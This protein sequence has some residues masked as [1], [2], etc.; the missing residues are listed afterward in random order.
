MKAW[1]GKSVM[2]VAIGHTI[3]GLIVFGP[4]LRTF[5]DGGIVNT[6]TAGQ[7]PGREAAFWFLFTGFAILVIGGLVD[8][9]EKHDLAI[10]L[11]VGVSTAIL[12][13][14]GIIV[15]PMSGFWLMIIPLVGLARSARQQ[16]G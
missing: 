6:I 10:P 15:M 14:I 16:R 13:I 3:V 11:F 8:Y 7:N 12:T 9:L 4:A 2:A 5:F 1:I